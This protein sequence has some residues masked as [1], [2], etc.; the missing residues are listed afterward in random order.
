M[1][2]GKDNINTVTIV[3]KDPN[4][5]PPTPANSGSLESP[6]VKKGILKIY[7]TLPLASR[8]S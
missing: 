2:I 6:L 7:F 5:D 1:P 8:S 4:N 3:K